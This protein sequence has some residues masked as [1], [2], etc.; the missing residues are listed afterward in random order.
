MSYKQIEGFS[1]MMI[2]ETHAEICRYIMRIY[3]CGFV[4]ESKSNLV[5]HIND[6]IAGLQ[7]G[8]E[9]VIHE[10]IYLS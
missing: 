6:M 2:K 10:Y 1:L 3:W 8:K 4:T 5:S 9:T 7:G